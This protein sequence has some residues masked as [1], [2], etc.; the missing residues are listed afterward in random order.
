MPRILLS[1]ER[2]DLKNISLV[3][4]CFEQQYA[5]RRGVLLQVRPPSKQEPTVASAELTD[6]FCSG[7]QT[8]QGYCP[9]LTVMIL[10]RTVNVF[11]GFLSRALNHNN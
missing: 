2:L 4:P 10:S 1:D 3:L 9:D 5:T 6:L 7:L 8:M 11:Q